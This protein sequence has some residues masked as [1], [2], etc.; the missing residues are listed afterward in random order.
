VQV[1]LIAPE[2]LIAESIKAK[3]LASLLNQL[4]RIVFGASEKARCG[5]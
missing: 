5:A 3:N 2:R 1:Q 4:R